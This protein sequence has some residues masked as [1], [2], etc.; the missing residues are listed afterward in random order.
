[1]GGAFWASAP[2]SGY[3]VDNLGPAM[4][5]PFT[6]AYAGGGTHLHWGANSES[7]L[8]GY[9]LHRGSSPGFVP[10]PGNLVSEQPD[11]GYVDLGPAGSYYKLA[12][13]D[14]HGNVSPYALLSPSGTTDVGPARPT[15]MWLAP[16]APNPARTGAFFRFAAP[17]QARV[18]L[19]LYDISG[20][21][22]RM[23]RNGEIEPGEDSRPLD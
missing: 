18:R 6:G 9:R 10:G 3:S 8:A 12:A 14:V 17:H 2:D 19:A 5:A 4:P 20:R 7:D 22:V 11:T 21:E 16:P 15:T 23:L 1:S 13:V